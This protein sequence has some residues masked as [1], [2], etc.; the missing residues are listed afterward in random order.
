MD[1]RIRAADAN[2]IGAA[3][4]TLRGGGM[5]V[6]PTETVY[7]LGADARSDR[8]VAKIFET[9]G[10]PQFNPLIA[11]VADL[12][13]AQKYGV[14]D[15]RA[16][17]LAERFWP[18]PL[19][20]VVKRR[21]GGGLSDLACAGLDTIALRA[22]AHPV[23]QALLRAF[24]GPLA[25]PSANLSGKL[26]PTTA[27]DAD[28]AMRGGAPF[29][30]DGGPCDVGLESTIIAADGDELRLL[31]P[32]GLPLE[33][34]REN[35]GAIASAGPIVA[36]ERPQAPGALESH[37]A[38]DARLRLNAAAPEQGESWLGFG[39]DQILTET[40]PR[41]SLSP[42]GD[43]VEAAANLFASLRA[44]DAAGADRIAVA[45]IPEKGLGRAINDRLRRAAAPRPSYD[46]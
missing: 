16:V 3:A 2:M 19:T 43:L 42:R 26:S 23:A 17:T 41:R 7:G 36:G 10:R 33:A 22:P 20:L 31:R 15:P 40:A 25:A 5:V 11:H 18:G 44:L 14:L 1:D 24:G 12:A 37:Y 9:K 32:G 21:A 13:A 39:P 27:A 8:A 28:A 30:L 38:P 34:L 46:V 35:V 45:P 6:F 4:E 29:I